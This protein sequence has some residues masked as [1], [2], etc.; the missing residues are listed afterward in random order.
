MKIRDIFAQGRRSISFEFFPPGTEQGVASL[1]RTVERLKGYNP[2]YVSVTYGAGGSTKDKTIEIVTQMHKDEGLEAMSH[3][4]CVS[5]S[6]DQVHV[7][8]SRLQAAGVD[9]ILALRGDPPRGEQKF[10]APDDGFPY[11]SELIAYMRDNFDFGIAASSFP[12]GHPDSVDLE[13]DM[14]YHKMKVD[15]GADFLIT[16]LFFDNQ[17]FFAFMDRVRR[18]GID[19]PVVAGVLPIQSTAQIRRFTALCGAKIPPH[20]DKQLERYADD[21]ESAREL[22]V[23][24]ASRQV[25]ELWSSGVAG[26]HIYT[27]NRSYSAS[28]IL[29]GLELPRK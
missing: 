14:I 19:V 18:I 7:L 5:Q 25:E 15:M 2:D 17:D 1:S 10:V 11:A 29:D 16:Q 28:K 27:L 9:N 26:I 23:E 24:Y 8:L 6:R 22:G 3:M 21:D 13:K 4:T 20:L 12:E